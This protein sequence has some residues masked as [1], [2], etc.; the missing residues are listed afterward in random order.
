VARFN[1]D[2]LNEKQLRIAIALLNQEDEVVA[3]LESAAEQAIDNA[4]EPFGL[5]HIHVADDGGGAAGGA[6]KQTTKRAASSEV[7]ATSGD[8]RFHP[9]T[10]LAAEVGGKRGGNKRV[11]KPRLSADQTLS[12]Q[13]QGKYIA[14]IRSVPKSKRAHFKGL[15]KLQGR[16]AAIDAIYAAYPR[17]N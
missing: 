7:Q 1:Y 13:L 4:L 17:A 15:V 9:N 14:A 12:R 8:L 2:N 3:A 6:R 5:S 11:R 16:Q 10:H